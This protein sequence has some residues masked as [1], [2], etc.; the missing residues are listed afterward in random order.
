M[1]TWTTFAPCFVWVFLG[2]PHLERLRSARRINA[3]LRGVTAAVVGVILN[4]A[5]W[6]A[7]HVVFPGGAPAGPDWFAVATMAAAFVALQ[8]FKTGLLP[9]I[10]MGGLLGL[11]WSLLR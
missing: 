11:E 1:T 6:F 2:A 5:V 10:A 3:A 7:W 8:R 4:L 9:V